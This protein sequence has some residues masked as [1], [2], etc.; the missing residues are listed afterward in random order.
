MPFKTVD[1]NEF[2]ELRQGFEKSY[3]H[4]A[5]TEATVHHCEYLKTVYEYA[6]DAHER[7]DPNFWEAWQHEACRAVHTRVTTAC[8]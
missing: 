3:S 4:K 1:R 5:P 7:G 8:A 2:Y 6:R